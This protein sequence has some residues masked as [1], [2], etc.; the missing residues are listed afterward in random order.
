MKD[1]QT[2][3]DEMAVAATEYEK[4]FGS[5][6]DAELNLGEMWAG[7][8]PDI[9]AIEIGLMNVAVK[10]GTPLTQKEIDDATGLD[11]S[12]HY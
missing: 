6:D 12:V 2:V 8:D 1:L 3:M 9:M 4:V 5:I 10:R 11:S 7:L